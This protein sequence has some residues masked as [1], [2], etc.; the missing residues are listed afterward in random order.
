MTIKRSHS[1]E[2]TAPGVEQAT[3]SAARGA[4]PVRARNPVRIL[5]FDHTAVWSGGEIALYHLVLHLDR[6]RYHPVVVLC[7]EGPLATRLR[8]TGI[9]THILPLAESVTQTR[10]DS[11]GA[12]SILR[13][14]DIARIGHYI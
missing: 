5:L 10:K 8:E 7:S 6:Q 14:K 13:L 12:S 2:R 1:P 9:E 11:L 3:N 4:S